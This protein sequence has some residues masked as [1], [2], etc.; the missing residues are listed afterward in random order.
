MLQETGRRIAF[1]FLDEVKE[2]FC[3]SHG[4]VASTAL[5]YT[6]D[7]AF[8]ADMEQLVSKYSDPRADQLTRVQ[9]EVENLRG[10]MVSNIENI[11]ERGERLE[12]LVQRTEGL[13]GQ[14]ILFKQQAS[15]FRRK[16]YWDLIRTRGCLWTL[17]LLALYCLAAVLCGP[18]LKCIT[19]D[20]DT[21]QP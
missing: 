20:A 4:T 10:T 17:V 13:D 1:A 2:K 18:T 7:A 12:L 21:S 16:N 11:L 5:A 15:S 3:A 9:A 19:G 14:T 8:D 6:L